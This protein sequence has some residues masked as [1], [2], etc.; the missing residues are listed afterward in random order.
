MVAVRFH[1]LLPVTAMAAGGMQLFTASLT[2]SP[3]NTGLGFLLGTLGVLQFVQPMFVYTGTEIQMRNL[4]GM[5]MKTHD[6]PDRALLMVEG[7][8]VLYDGQTLIGS[9]SGMVCRGEDWEALK[10]AIQVPD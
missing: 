1:V 2:G 7:N 8:S 4:L 6:V 5:T 9:F 10:S 3:L